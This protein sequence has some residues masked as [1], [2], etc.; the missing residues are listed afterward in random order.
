MI[1]IL[2]VTKINDQNFLGYYI[3]DNQNKIRTIDSAY[4]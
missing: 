3:I 4:R 1:K 2:A